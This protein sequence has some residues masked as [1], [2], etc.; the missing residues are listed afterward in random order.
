MDHNNNCNRPQATITN[1]K[2]KGEKRYFNNIDNIDFDNIAK[3]PKPPKDEVIKAHM[4]RMV[5]KK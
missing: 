3:E 1:R 5:K 2:N 4:S